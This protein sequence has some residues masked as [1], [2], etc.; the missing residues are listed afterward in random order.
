MESRLLSKLAPLA[1]LVVL[2]CLSLPL[3][4]QTPDSSDSD[5]SPDKSWISST[6]SS[7]A[8]AN[9]TRATDSHQ[10]SGNRTLD[11]HSVQRIGPNGSYEPYLDTETESVKVNASTRRTIQRTFTRGPD[12]ERVL[13]Q[14]TEEEKQSL[15]GGEVKLV[16]TTS[17]PDIN[18]SMLL[19]RREMENTKPTSPDARETHTTVF[20][21][22]ANGG[23]TAA[24]QIVEH[25]KRNGDKSAE[26]QRTTLVSD[27]NGNW[28]TGETREGTIKQDGKQRTTE[29]R[30]LRPD[31]EG[32]MSVVSRTVHKEAENP[33]GEQ[34]ET[35]ETYS[36][37]I[38]GMTPDGSLHLNQRITTVRQARPDGG[39]VTQ[40]QVEQPNPGD[41][42]AGLRVTVQSVDTVRPSA[43]ETQ[44]T[45]TVEAL[46]GGGSLGAVSV[47][48][49]KSDKPTQVEIAPAP[50]E[51][52]K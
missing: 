52:P 29:E 41:P 48:M 24:T 10:Q 22:S 6:D 45:R 39:A 50:S 8:N 4:A 49:G 36:T 11:I 13:T 47:D 21:P 34:R 32:N 16:R 20:I 12:G 35:V 19:V 44:E 9:A 51:K 27:G 38:P 33:A 5:K 7:I 37:Q 15:P 28:Q 2:S 26:Y 25:Q 46:D 43:G 30:V 1:G 23:L 40:Q 31:S 18:G 3:Y 14:V 42:S 17:N